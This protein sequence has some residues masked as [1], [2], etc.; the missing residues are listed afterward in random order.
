MLKE[1]REISG[2]SFETQAF[3][4]LLRMRAASWKGFCCDR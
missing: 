3:G 1:A 4:L 2:A